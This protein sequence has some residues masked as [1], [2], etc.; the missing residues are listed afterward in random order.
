MLLEIYLYGGLC[1]NMTKYPNREALRKAHDIYRDAMREFIFQYL[2]KR[3]KGETVNDLIT[4]VLK[5]EQHG[6]IDIKGISR[7]FSNSEC[8]NKFFSQQFG[9]DR[10]FGQHRYDIGSVTSLI[11]MGRNK[12]SHP[13][14]R[15]LDPDYTNTHLFLITEV[16]GEI[17]KTQ[18]KYEVQDIWD[19]LCSDEPEEHPAEA[20][21]TDLNQRLEEISAQLEMVKT[22]KAEY[23]DKLRRLEAEKV[24]YEELLDAVEKEKI[25]IETQLGTAPTRLNEMKAENTGLKKQFLEIEN[26][27]QAVELESDEHIKTLT[28]QLVDSE[29]RFKNSQKHLKTTHAVKTKLEQRLETTS[30]R[31]ENVEGKLDDRKKDLARNLKQLKVVETENTKWLLPNNRSWLQISEGLR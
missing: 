27:L 7:I 19:D 4:R 20:E 23:G 29:E 31:L 30:T 13:G 1:I 18:A 25:E 8:W 28:E 14:S 21:N 5:R 6:L 16:L 9:H 24:E 17:G 26:R 10:Q 15:D 11:V 3:V 22:E 2:E 12:V